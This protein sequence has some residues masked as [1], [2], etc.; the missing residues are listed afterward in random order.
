MRSFSSLFWV[1]NYTPLCWLLTASIIHRVHRRYTGWMRP[2]MKVRK[3]KLYPSAAVWRAR[4]MSRW[5]TGTSTPGWYAPAL[6][7]QV[8]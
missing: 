7:A 8:Y 5:F 2:R 4:R 1:L 3:P 6:A